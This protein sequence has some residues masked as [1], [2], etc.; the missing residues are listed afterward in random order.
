MFCDADTDT[1]VTKQVVLKAPSQHV[2][3]EDTVVRQGN[4]FV[5]GTADDP[6]EHVFRNITFRNSVAVKTM[7]ACHIKFK[8]SQTGLVHDVHF[9]NITVRDP[10]HYAVGI[11][12]DGQGTQVGVGRSALQLSSAVRVANVSFV[13]IRGRAAVAGRF[14]CNA[15]PRSQCRG[16]RLEHVHL[17]V[18]RGNATHP[19]GCTFVNAFGRGLDVSPASCVPPRA[20]SVMAS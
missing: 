6:F 20:G 9:D 18:P 14:H 12:L 4:G 15:Q 16:I 7:F 11:N 17:D 3:I 8:G 1:H 10:T 19:T 13:R 2:L 5:V